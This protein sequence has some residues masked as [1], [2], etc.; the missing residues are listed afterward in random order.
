MISLAFMRYPGHQNGELLCFQVKESDSAKIECWPVPYMVLEKIKKAID[1]GESYDMQPE[2]EIGFIFPHNGGPEKPLLC[3]GMDCYEVELDEFKSA[4]NSTWTKSF[5]AKKGAF[6]FE[7]TPFVR[8]SARIILEEMRIH[9]I[10]K[11]TIGVDAWK[12]TIQRS[13]IGSDK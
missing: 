12:L 4:I 3:L 11:T 5:T 7:E 6:P 1:K 2:S 10:H 13:L 9:Q 8:W